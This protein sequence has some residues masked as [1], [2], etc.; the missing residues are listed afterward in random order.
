VGKSC[1]IQKMAETPPEGWA[2]LQCTVESK[3]HPTEMVG[4][5]YDQ[6]RIHAALSRK[7]A[8]QGGF[9]KA[10]ET[11]AGAEV[12]GWRLPT[13]ERAWKRLLT[14]LVEGLADYGRP[15]VVIVLDEFP[16]M[17][18]NMLEDG[19]PGLAAEVLDTLRELR[20]RY[21]AAGR[22][23]FLLT[24]SIGLH[25]IISELKDKHGYTGNPTNDLAAATLAGMTH[26][27][28]AL[29][30]RKYLDEE[31]IERLEP[32]RVVSSMRRATD[33]LPLYVAYVCSRFQRANRTPVTPAAVAAEVRAMLLDTEVE[34]FSDAA[35]RI[36][37]RYS[38]LGMSRT[39]AEVLRVLCR[40]R[41]GLS[42]AL[43]VRSIVDG[44]LAVDASAVQP[45]FDL[46]LRDHYLARSISSGQR[47]YAFRHEIM[48]RWWR[49][50]RG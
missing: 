44:G 27:D 12:G 5:I 47:R 24:G 39:A 4:E 9:S 33:G 36:E 45:V 19:Q 15:R 18:S 14:L 25:L 34:W 6:A 43:V 11:L 49:L 48:R 41:G 23:R 8:W 17:L 16:H 1:V 31:G 3:R 29:M 40:R 21:Q 20:Q 35:E 2:V 30:C 42:E 28:V 26:E 13:V 37:R 10:Y 38:R 32:D 46:L 7:A 50:N 22:F